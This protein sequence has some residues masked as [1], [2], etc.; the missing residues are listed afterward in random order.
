M[1]NRQ[2][3]FDLASRVPRW[4]SNRVG[5]NT[6]FKLLYT[7]ALVC[8]GLFEGVVQGVCAAFPG[9]G[10]P[11]ALPLIGRSRNLVRGEADTDATYG[12]KLQA[13]R[14]AWKG[15]GSSIG[16][17]LQIQ[18]FLGNT[19]TVRVVSRAQE[20]VS[21]DPT[22]AVTITTAPWDWD[23]NAVPSRAADWSDIW[24]IVYACEWT[25]T[26]ATLAALVG[27]WGSHNGLGFGHLVGRKAVD[28]ILSLVA[29]WKGAH[30]R[31]RAI[32]WSYD[33]TWFVPGGS[34][35]KLPNGHWGFWG[36]PTNN[37]LTAR[38]HDVGRYWE[39]NGSD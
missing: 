32:I 33:A 5:L 2:I 17:A 11:S 14:A 10:T 16:L 18:R 3:R 27:L 31:V 38:R 30:T 22:G 25:Q 29:T 36:D 12:A 8:D 1:S 21:V 23:S 13:W 39:P 20:W 24:I 4:L 37:Y 15:C 6:G 35:A 28:T 9:L 19:P 34:P 26:G 7:L